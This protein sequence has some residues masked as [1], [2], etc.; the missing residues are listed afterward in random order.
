MGQFRRIFAVLKKH[1]TNTNSL[2]ET[3]ETKRKKKHK[4]K[5]RKKERKGKEKEKEKEKIN[6]HPYV[7]EN[8]S[9]FAGE[10]DVLRLAVGDV[11]AKEVHV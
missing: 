2:K 5:K 7:G 11:D 3:N 9:N 8:E 10:L 4:R 6:L 1:N